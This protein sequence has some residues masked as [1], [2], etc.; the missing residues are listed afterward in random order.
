MLQAPPLSCRRPLVKS[1]PT[2]ATRTLFHAAFP[3]DFRPNV[4]SQLVEITRVLLRVLPTWCPRALPN[5]PH[6]RQTMVQPLP[7]STRCLRSLAKSG[8]LRTTAN[9]LRPRLLRHL[10]ALP[11]FR[12]PQ[13]RILLRVS[14]DSG[15]SALT[16]LERTRPIVE[17]QSPPVSFVRALSEEQSPRATE[18]PLQAS[19][20]HSLQ[21][22]LL[23][24]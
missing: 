16:G 24:S 4:N 8:Q 21:R 7:T 14:L 11:S 2:R 23:C 10:R 6:R 20:Q 3:S 9:M 5:P 19:P 12:S 17:F 1:R 15:Q 22:A 18:I 13:N